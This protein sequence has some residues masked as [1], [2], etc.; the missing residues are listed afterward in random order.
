MNGAARDGHVE[1]GS[2]SHVSLAGKYNGEA[3]VDSF[4]VP[5][6][7]HDNRFL[8][9]Q[10]TRRAERSTV[11]LGEARDPLIKSIDPIRIPPQKLRVTGSRKSLESW[12]GQG[13]SPPCKADRN[14]AYSDRGSDEVLIQRKDH[15]R[16]GV[17]ASG[18]IQE[19][20]ERYNQKV[21]GAR[22]ETGFSA[23]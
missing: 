2:L 22:R 13:F 12:Q 5:K 10:I 21:D 11:F 16:G 18:E 8:R 9:S 15:P 3:G 23:T 14:C 1:Y 17:H 4:T 7:R 19:Q 6:L 20:N